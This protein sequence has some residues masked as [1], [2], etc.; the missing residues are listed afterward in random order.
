MYFGP[1]DQKNLVDLDKYTQRGHDLLTQ[2]VA[3][4]AEA[5]LV[6]GDCQEE[7]VIALHGM[8]NIWVMAS[9]N[10]EAEL[11]YDLARRSSGT[12]WWV[13][14]TREQKPPERQ[15]DNDGRAANDN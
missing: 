4:A 5:G 13:S 8:I 6:R 12:C 9:L 10:D 1:D 14:K 11:N 2:G 15:S 3:Q 7:L